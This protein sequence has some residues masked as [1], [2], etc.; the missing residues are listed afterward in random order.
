M[1][2]LYYPGCALKKT[3]IDFDESFQAAAP[4]LGIEIKELEKWACC[5]ATVAK[6]VNK[7][8]AESLPVKA[9]VCAEQENMDLLTLCPSCYL[10]H[11]KVAHRLR[12]DPA[13]RE[14]HS[15]RRPPK[16]KQLLEVLAVDLGAEEIRRSV[17][18]SLEGIKAIPYYGCLVVRP[19]PLGG[20]ESL[21]NPRALES[22]IAATGA[23]PVFFPYKIDC[24][25]GGIFLSKEKVALK[26]S[27]TILKEAKK[28]S[29]DCIVVVCPLCHF[30][31]D[32]KQRAIEKE[33]G[34]KIGIPVFYITQLIGI[35]LGIEYK[36]LGILR[37]ITPPKTFLK[38]INGARKELSQ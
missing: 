35:A 34:E 16:V 9:L 18:R 5:G 7:E 27:A 6:S 37:L 4:M 28:L 1:R 32:A 25:G 17:V 26:L 2:Y 15:L 14:I 29:P 19:F 24:C 20:K 22:L 38:R 10:N 23:Q 3:A 8:L 11:Q 13:F 12:D 30:M 33:T 36:K 31:L 21:E